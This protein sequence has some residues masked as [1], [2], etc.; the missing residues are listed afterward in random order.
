MNQD[1]A[2]YTAPQ[3][4]AADLVVRWLDITNTKNLDAQM[5]ITDDEIVYRGDPAETLGHGARGFCTAYNFTLDVSWERLDELYVVA[6]PSE[7]LVLIK[8]TDM[9]FAAG[10]GMGGL[11]GNPVAVATLVRVRNGKLIEWYD[12]PINRVGAFGANGDNTRPISIGVLPFCA[13][14]PTSP[15]QR[16]GTST[17]QAFRLP[18]PT[19]Q[20]PGPKLAIGMVPYGTVK[21]EGRMNAEE[22]TALHAIRAWFAA[23]KAN[24]PLLLASFT[25]KNAVFRA[26]SD[27]HS[28]TNGRDAMLKAICATMGGSIDLTDVYVIGSDFN[29]SAI[30]RWTRTDAAGNSVPMGSFFRVKNGVIREWMD[31]QLDGAPI[32]ANPNTAACQKVNTTLAAYSPLPVNATQPA[33]ANP[34]GPPPGP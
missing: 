8:R 11:G 4:A 13:K 33:N 34:F 5:A 15:Y 20:P 18:G 2:K 23:R 12:A 32:A 29:A 22:V 25:D 16:T 19:A 21:D 1:P 6:G 28:I 10:A 24:D 7:G 14:Y 9:N 17:T 30:A 27:A 26:T 31:A 3:K